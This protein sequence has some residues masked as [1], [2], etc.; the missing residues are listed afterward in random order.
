[1][2]IYL[3]KG[4]NKDKI[5]EWQFTSPKVTIYGT[6]QLMSDKKCH[7]KWESLSLR[8]LLAKPEIPFK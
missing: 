6:T 7:F 2:A 3:Y 1:M 8:A 5:Y 4:K